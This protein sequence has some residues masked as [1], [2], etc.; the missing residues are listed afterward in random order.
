MNAIAKYF[1]LTAVL[2]SPAIAKGQ[3][4][5]KDFQKFQMA[6]SLISSFY[7]DTINKPEL[8]EQAVVAMLK[9]LDPHSV[10]ISAKEVEAVNQQLNSSFDGIGIEF[11]IL[12]DTLMVVN[13]I[14][15]GPSE[16]VGMKAGDRILTVDGKNI[17][18]IGIKNSDVF[19]LL[20]GPKGTQISLGISRKGSSQLLTF[21]VVRDQIPIYSIDAAYMATS[22]I[23]YIKVNKFA[24]NTYDE[25]AE[26]LKKLQKNKLEGLILDLRGNG[27][28][29]L[30][31]AIDMADEFLSNNKM[32]VYTQGNASPRRDFKATSRGSYEKGPLVVLM[33]E[34][35]AS[36]SEIV[37]GAVQDHDRGIVI[38]RR[39]FGKGLVQRQFTLLDGS[40]I[41]LTTAKYYT[42][43]GR[44]IQ[45]PYSDGLDAYHHEIAERIAHGELTNAD[46]IK[47]NT[48]ETYKTLVSGRLV[49][50]GGGIMP[51]KFVPIDTSMYSNYYRELFTKGILNQ[52]AINYLDQNRAAITSNYPNINNFTQNFQVEQ[53]LLDQLFEAAQ[54]DGIVFNEA[55]YRVSENL[56][57]SQLKANLAKD[58]WNTSAFFE[59]INPIVDVYVQAIKLIENPNAYQTLLK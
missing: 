7:V 42:P 22:K 26:A 47:T 28:G 40:Q 39:S 41:R 56:I 38:G 6:W 16:K 31:A 21:K 52:T 4:N 24:A 50:G 25:F 53:T 3:V 51:D 33:D 8:A 46:S 36:A 49:Y 9:S 12:Y 35:S 23:G 19:K 18:G 29:Y 1:L 2:L 20:R 10:Y 48:G 30:N 57:K 55:E 13:T 27:G 45:K 37:A 44:C 5:D 14:P 58:L 11:N 17:A 43:S 15:G 32:I 34:S 59:L 54:K